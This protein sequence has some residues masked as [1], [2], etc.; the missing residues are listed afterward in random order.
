MLSLTNVCLSDKA[1]KVTDLSY[2]PMLKEE[3]LKVMIAEKGIGIAAPQ[4]GIS[5]RIF[6]FTRNNGE[7]V[8][9][10][11]P[12][13]KEVARGISISQEGC[14]SH[15]GLQVTVQRYPAIGAT[16]YDETGKFFNQ[17]L[18]DQEAIIFQ[19]EMD[20]LNGITIVNKISSTTS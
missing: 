18:Q 9:A 3:L 14:L 4:V 10:A 12:Q 11:N 1:E 20:H 8:L 5:E 19:H 6:L 2:L 16:W 13:I 17:F 15:P 7:V